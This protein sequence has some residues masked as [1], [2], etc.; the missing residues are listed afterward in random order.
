MNNFFWKKKFCSKKIFLECLLDELGSGE[1]EEKFLEVE[2]ERER[3]RERKVKNL[4]KKVNSLTG[5]K[6]V[7]VVVLF[8]LIIFVFLA[9]EFR[10][11][12]RP[13]AFALLEKQ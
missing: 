2:R 8:F 1:H 12:L 3:E 10:A 11:P 13:S 6:L 5:T 7:L 9:I 4:D